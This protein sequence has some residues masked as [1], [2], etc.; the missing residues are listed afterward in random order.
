M[1]NVSY[2]PSNV[3]LMARIQDITAALESWAP[4]AYQESYDNAG[5]IVGDPQTPLTGILICLDA[6]EAVVAEAGRRGCNLVVA[7]HPVV[8]KGLKK[9]NTGSYVGRA[10]VAAVKHDVALYAAHTNLD[11]VQGGVNFHIAARLGLEGV[12]ILAP[13]KQVLQKLV[14]F[15]PAE[16]TLAVLDALYAAGAGQIGNYIN[17]SF[18]TP[19]TGTFKPG[20]AAN[21]HIG[22]A[23]KQEE[24][25]EDRV[26]VIFP[27]HRSAQ[28]LAA[29]RRAHPY[30]EVAY[31]LTALE[32]ENQEVGA[33][34]V[35]T[36]PVPVPEMQ[37][38]TLLKERMG[39]GCVR[40][41]PLR[42]KMVQKVAVCGGTGSFLTGDAIRAGAD[43]FVTA[44]VKYHE[45]FD[46]DG[47]IVIADIG[48]Y[49]SEVFTKELIHTHLSEKFSNIA[50]HLSEVATNPVN[51]L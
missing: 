29:L 14:A 49:E 13:K 37:F 45:F 12:R 41:T 18:R 34:A 43:V 35:G 16:N 23:G 46:A 26:E 5:L 22:A 20:A 19:G 40:Y 8:F 9:I 11:N 39:A 47:K 27:A 4:P 38:L 48:H 17:C 25:S 28:V 31:Y 44:D 30:E 21:P 10:V 15:V 50:I 32:N 2:L 7:H 33:G 3:S 24:V 1:S 51:Y 42:E 36:L 6:T